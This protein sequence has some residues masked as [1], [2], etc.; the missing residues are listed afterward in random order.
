MIRG[1]IDN[2]SSRMRKEEVRMDIMRAE[3]DEDVWRVFSGVKLPKST[4]DQ[5]MFDG[6]SVA[7]LKPNIGLKAKDQATI[8]SALDIISVLF[9]RGCPLES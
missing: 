7:V 8:S 9:L 6:D 4:S 1:D 3:N 2:L 5:S